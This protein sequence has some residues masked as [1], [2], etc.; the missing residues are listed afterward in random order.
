MGVKRTIEVRKKSRH[1]GQKGELIETVQRLTW[2]EDVGRFNPM[3][4]RYQGQVELVRSDNSN[5]SDPVDRAKDLFLS[6]YIEP[7][8]QSALSAAAIGQI[9]GM[10]RSDKKVA[11]SRANGLRG[12]RPR[13]KTVTP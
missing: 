5:L 8:T 4:C 9:G 1:L 7:E 12:G 10:S 6:L 13:K 2:F 3:F 11:A